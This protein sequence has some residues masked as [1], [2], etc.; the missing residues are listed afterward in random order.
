MLFR[1]AAQ[2]RELLTSGLPD[3]DSAVVDGLLEVTGRWPLMPR[4]VNKILTN[5]AGLAAAGKI[6]AQAWS[7]SGDC[8][9]AVRRWLTRWAGRRAATSM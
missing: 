9:R 1:S 4:L 2:A 3:L 5:Y 6:S 7:W 8:G